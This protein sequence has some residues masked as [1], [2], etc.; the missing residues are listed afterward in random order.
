MKIHSSL[1]HKQ[2]KTS[3][4]NKALKV[5]TGFTA[6]LGAFVAACNPIGSCI[7]GIMAVYYSNKTPSVYPAQPTDI[8]SRKITKEDIK[9]A[10]IMG[11]IHCLLFPLGA[12]C[13][14]N[15]AT[16]AAMKH[17]E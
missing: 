1:A 15:Q 5:L 12:V 9:S 16:V 14:A 4:H 3:N 8:K 6:G 13:A 11:G 17:F 7:F 2:P 10:A